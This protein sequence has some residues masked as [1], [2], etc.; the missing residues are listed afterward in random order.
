MVAAETLANILIFPLSAKRCW[1]FEFKDLSRNESNMQDMHRIQGDIKG[2]E[3][4]PPKK[5]THST[6]RFPKPW[7]KM[8]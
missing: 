3:Q 5:N 2:N 8:D 6:V 7:I 1:L 4:T